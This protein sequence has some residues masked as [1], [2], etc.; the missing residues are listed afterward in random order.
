M[1]NLAERIRAFFNPTPTRRLTVYNERLTP[2]FLV[3]TMDVDRA[4]SIIECADDGDPRDLFNLY[5]DIILAHSHLQ[6]EFGKRKLAVLGDPLSIQPWNKKDAQDVTAAAAIKSMVD[7]YEGFTDACIHLLDSTLWP[8]AVMEKVFRPSSKPGLRYELAELV[9]VP[10]PLFDF[11]SGKLKIRE[12]DPLTGAAMAVLDDPDPARYIIHRGHLLTFPDW[13]GGP[14]RS[15]VMWWMLST[16]D[17]DWWA[18]FLDKYGSPFLV[19]KYDQADDASRR[20]LERA[21][22][23]AVRIGGLVVSKQ[24]EV[25]MEQAMAGASGDAYKSFHDICNRE[26][27]KLVIGQTLS[28]ESQPLGIGGGASK[29]HEDVRGDI[30]QWDGFRLGQT[31]RAQLFQQF[32]QINGLPGRAPKAVWGA[33]SPDQLLATGTLLQSLSQAGLQV[34]DESI[35]VLSERVGLTLQ[36]SATPALPSGQGNPP[37]P[38]IFSA[39]LPLLKDVDAANETITRNAAADLAQAFRGSLAPIRRMIGESKSPGELAEK[40]LASY[41]DW[42]SGRVQGIIADALTAFAANAVE[43]QAEE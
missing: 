10:D 43:V 37:R 41:P 31:W 27:S 14:L 21:F 35:P 6:N 39:G 13:R 4:H 36:R 19:G 3:Q 28:S 8:V 17:R 38:A 16:F 23:W 24:T 12:T 22:Q 29:Q 1:P 34:A 33:E 32:L 2:H 25:E 7:E 5:R 42:P 18:R 26:I 11:T 9:P 15:L 20:V 30:R 40:I